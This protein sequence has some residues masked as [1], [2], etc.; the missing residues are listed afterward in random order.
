MNTKSRN[1]QKIA[2]IVLA[3]LLAVALCVLVFTLIKLKNELSKGE[4]SSKGNI[5]SQEKNERESSL[6][7]GNNEIKQ[8]LL[9]SKKLPDEKITLVDK[10]KDSATPFDV[11]DLFPG[12][13]VS[14]VFTVS[15]KDKSAKSLI[16]DATVTSG[17]VPGDKLTLTVIADSAV[18]YNGKLGDVSNK[19]Y[20]VDGIC[21]V[22]YT[23][24]VALDKTAGNEYANLDVYLTFKWS[25]L[26]EEREPATVTYTDGVSDVV[27]FEDQVFNVFKEDDT[28]AF[29][30]TPTRE[31]FIFDGWAPSV[32]E[33]V[34]DSVTYTAQWAV[35]VTFV[36]NGQES[37]V[38]V[39]VGQKVE[40]P[41]APYKAAYGF[42]GWYLDEEYTQKYDF[43]TRLSKSTTI[44][45]RFFMW[46]DVDMNGA[47]TANDAN[48]ISQYVMEM[49][50]ENIKNIL[51]AR[52]ST[53]GGTATANDANFIA[54]YV[55]EAI[56]DFPVSELCKGY[57]F[58][59]ES[60]A[61][62][63]PKK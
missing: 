7:F 40:K 57:E 58:D 20:N 25:F 16:F 36:A 55:M 32:S 5:I 61:V 13:S 50:N 8:L 52:V 22:D 37:H 17:N 56:D 27:L 44:Y 41:E 11:S 2:I 31:G 51:A 10:G 35:D 63:A 24:I 53:F 3:V 19:A 46:G 39:R 21:D 34:T 26:Y 6:Y 4:S 49:D 54:R 60:G 29:V 45:A 62:I 43:E 12:D 15:V 1:K 42:A 30:G 14:K 9:M 18:L 33:K 38:K 28:P 48:L 59:L 23:F 47:V